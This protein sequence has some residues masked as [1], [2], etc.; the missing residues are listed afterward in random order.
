MKLIKYFI[1]LLNG[2]I[3]CPCCKRKFHAMSFTTGYKLCPD[4]Y[5]RKIIWIDDET[6][7][8]LDKILNDNGAEAYYTVNIELDL[9]DYNGAIRQLANDLYFANC[10][11]NDKLPLDGIPFKR[12]IRT[13][14]RRT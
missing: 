1:S 14:E 5:D 11:L 8:H 7:E 2:E 4:C 12:T 13:K 6:K 10:L 3:I 9:K